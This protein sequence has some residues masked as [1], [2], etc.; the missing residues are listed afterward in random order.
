MSSLTHY[1]GIDWCFMA[2]RKARLLL[3]QNSTHPVDWV[4]I[5]YRFS[6]CTMAV[7]NNFVMIISTLRCY[8]F[9]VIA[10]LWKCINVALCNILSILWGSNV[11]SCDILSIVYMLLTALYVTYLALYRLSTSI[12]WL[13]VHR[14]P[15]F[16]RTLVPLGLPL[17]SSLE[18]NLKMLHIVMFNLG[19][20]KSSMLCYDQMQRIQVCLVLYQQCKHIWMY[21][22]LHIMTLQV[23]HYNGVAFVCILILRQLLKIF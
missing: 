7:M 14:W 16:S 23:P 19:V 8:R 1:L 12:V 9:C 6:M 2:L 10:I 5:E 20:I 11:S 17:V 4:V 3:S 15:C 22:N 21:W 18:L 13:M